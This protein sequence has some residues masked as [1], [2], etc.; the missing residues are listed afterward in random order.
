[1]NNLKNWFS[2]LSHNDIHAYNKVKSKN[3][4]I[5]FNF[6]QIPNTKT[7]VLTVTIMKNRVKKN[8]LDPQSFARVMS[9]IERSLF[10]QIGTGD[11]EEEYEYYINIKSELSPQWYLQLCCHRIFFIPEN[12]LWG[13]IKNLFNQDNIKTMKDNHIEEIAVYVNTENYD[14]NGKFY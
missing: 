14:F 7:V 9:V 5:C 10:S 1:M 13:V 8:S 3:L 12:N 2:I 11:I 4:A 6:L